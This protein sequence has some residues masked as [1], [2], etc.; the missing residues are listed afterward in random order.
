MLLALIYPLLYCRLRIVFWVSGVVSLIGAFF[1]GSKD[2]GY[3]DGYKVGSILSAERYEATDAFSKDYAKFVNE[4]MDQMRAENMPGFLFFVFLFLAVVVLAL[5]TGVGRKQVVSPVNDLIAG[6]EEF[7]GQM[8]AAWEQKNGTYDSG[9]SLDEW[10]RESFD[11]GDIKLA[12]FAMRHLLDQTSA[13]TYPDA[14]SNPVY[15]PSL[16]QTLASVRAGMKTIT[17][18]IFMFFNDWKVDEQGRLV[19]RFS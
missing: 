8:I 14:Q 9:N 7:K 19:G 17:G 4:Q 16:Q 11:Q 13:P 6:S 2:V 3:Y 10:I 12:D 15:P 18:Q 5:A 1:F